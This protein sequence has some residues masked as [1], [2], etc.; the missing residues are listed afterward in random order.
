[1]LSVSAQPSHEAICSRTALPSGVAGAMPSTWG[2]TRSA[3][4]T[5]ASFWMSAISSIVT[6]VPP[7]ASSIIVRIRE[8]R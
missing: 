1:M 6:P 7:S 3:R 8:A 2:Q 5:F 4:R